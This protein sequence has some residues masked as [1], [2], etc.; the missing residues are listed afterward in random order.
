MEAGTATRGPFKTQRGFKFAT[1]LLAELGPVA[2]LLG[3]QGK[4]TVLSSLPYWLPE[5]DDSDK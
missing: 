5:K 2:W 3:L 4:G 1:N